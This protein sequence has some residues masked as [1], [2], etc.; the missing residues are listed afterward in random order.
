[1]EDLLLKNLIYRRYDDYE[2]EY[3]Y[4]AERIMIENHLEKFLA[5][6]LII[7]SNGGYILS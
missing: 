3:Q 4:V 5:E 2:K 6:K 7:E 1:V